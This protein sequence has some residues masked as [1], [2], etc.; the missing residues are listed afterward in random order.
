MGEEVLCKEGMF[1]DGKK[2]GDVTDILGSKEK[3]DVH[4]ANISNVE[5]NVEEIL[6]KDIQKPAQTSVGKDQIEVDAKTDII[7]TE[8]TEKI[9]MDDNEKSLESNE[10]QPV[11][12]EN[13][14]NDTEETGDKDIVEEKSE[15]IQ[16]ADDFVK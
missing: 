10:E 7:A 14:V 3:D 2:V 13:E 9:I 6:V 16:S 8:E 12:D 5:D 11:E 1:K 4:Q 15:D